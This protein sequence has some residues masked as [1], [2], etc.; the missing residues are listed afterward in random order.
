MKCI[1]KLLI[2]PLVKVLNYLTSSRLKCQDLNLCRH[3]ATGFGTG[4]YVYSP[5]NLEKFMLDYFRI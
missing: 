5:L 1:Y 2:Y 3:T 4:K